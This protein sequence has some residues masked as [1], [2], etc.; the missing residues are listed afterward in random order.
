MP[1]FH[2]KYGENLKSLSRGLRSNLTDAER[3]L[4]FKLRNGQIKGYL[5][6][7]QKPIGKYVVDFYCRKARL[8]IEID[9]GEHYEDANILADKIRDEEFKKTG[10]KV[11]R[12]TNIDVMKNIENAAERISKELE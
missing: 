9:G 10:L 5:F 8:V 6:N 12:F 2:L 3:K 1:E 7:R 11:L 4:W